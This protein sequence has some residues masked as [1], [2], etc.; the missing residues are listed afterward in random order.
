MRKIRLFFCAA[1]AFLSFLQDA[2]AQ[3]PIITTAVNRTTSTAGGFLDDVIAAGPGRIDNPYMICVDGSDNLYIADYDNSRIRKVDAVTGIITT[4]AGSAATG[5]GGDG[6]PATLAQLGAPGGGSR[7]VVGVAVDAAGNIYIGDA[8]NNKIRFVNASTGIISTF[9]G[10]GT[11]GFSGDGGPA[12]AAQLNGPRGIAV[13]A[14]GNVYF[15]DGENQRIR[16][17]IAGV[18]TIITIA[19]NGMAGPGT[20]GVVATTQRINNVRGLTVDASGNVYIADQGNNR[21]RRIA[22]FTNIITTVAG[23]GTAGNGGMGGPATAGQL[24]GPLDVEFDALGNMYIA[25][26]GVNRVKRVNTSG[27]IS[28][29]A[30]G[31][32]MGG[33]G[34]DGGPATASTA[35]LNTPASIAILSNPNYFYISDRSN[36]KIRLV[37][38]NSLPFFTRGTR[39]DTFVCQNS[40]LNNIAPLFPVMDSDWA[41]YANLVWSV[42]VPALHGTATAT[43]SDS[44]NGT[45]ITPASV[46]YTPTLGYSGLDTFTVQITDGANTATTQVIVTVNPLPV[47]PPIGGP[48]EVCVGG[49]V[50]ETNSTGGGLWEASNS[51]VTIGSSTGIVT[52]VSVGFVTISY[53]VTNSC[54]FTRVV[55]IMTINTVPATPPAI[56]GPSIVCAGSGIILTNG[57]SG[58]VWT[59]SN[60][61]VATVGSAS[62]SVTGVAAG[63]VNITYTVTNSCGSAFVFAP[64]TVNPAPTPIAGSATSCVGASNTLTSSPAGIW[65][66]SNTAAATIG[67][68]SGVV[69]GVAPGTTTISYT[70]SNGCFAT[71][72][73]TVNNPP[74]PNTGTP[75]VCVGSTTTLS[76]ALPGGTWTSSSGIA[77]VGSSTGIVFGMTDGIPNITYTLGGCISVTTITINLVPFPINPPG[78][79]TMC[80]GGSAVLTSTPGAGTWSTVAGTG[81]VSLV[82]AGSSVTVTGATAGTA[83][84]SYTNSFGCARTK[85]VTVNITP[86]AISPTSASICVGNTV[87]L[88]NSVGGGTWTSGSANATV[89]SATGVVTG[90]T[91]GTANITYTIGSCSVSV[92]VTVNNGP[93]PIT[94]AG[95]VSVCV[96]ATA[97]LAD[98]TS[99]GTWS[100]VAGTGSV[101]LVAAGTSVTVTGVSAGTATISYTTGTGCAATKVI[102]VDN[103][104]AAISPSSAQVCTGS[105]VT[106][107]NS[108]SGGTWSSSATGVATVDPGG[109]VTGVAFGTATISYAIGTCVATAPVTVNLSPSAGTIV[110]SA[111]AC[112][113]LT[114]TLTNATSGGVWSSSNAAVATVGSTG[115]VTGVTVGPVIISYTVVNGCG[116]ATATHAMTVSAGASAGTITGVGML[117]AGTFTT[118]TSTVPG[119]TWSATNTR[120]TI[121]STGVLTGITPGIDT[122]LYSV[123]N[124]CGTAVSSHI[125][126]IGA[127]LTAGTISGP[128]SVCQGASITLTST[129]TGGA[130]TSSGP[131]ATVSGGVVTG[132]SGGMVTISYTVTSFC[133]TATATY[134]VLAIA[135]PDAGTVTGPI[136]LCAGMTAPYTTAGTGGT[137]SVTNATATITSGGVLTALSMGI[138]T[139]EYTVTN[140]CGTDVSSIAVTIGPA[141]TVSSNSGPAS[142]CEASSITLT[143][144][145]PGGVWSASNTNATVSGGVVTGVTAGSV[146]I[147]YTVTS[148]CGSVSAV[149]TIM[150]NPLPNAGTIVGPTIACVAASITLTDAAPGGTWNAS[151]SNATVSGGVVTGV[152]VGLVDISYTVTNSCGTA[153]AVSTITVDAAPTVAAISGPSNVCV[154]ATITLTD[155]TP[156]GTWSSS[157]TDATVSGG[158]VTGVTAG[159]TII[160]Y[161]VT[162]ACGSADATAA[163]TIDPLPDAGTIVGPSN[164]CVA[165]TITLT[166]AAPGGTWSSSS[167]D[168]TVVGGV[169]TGVTAG[170]VN[171]SYSV[172]NVCGT[173][174]AV[175]P[176]TVDPLPDAGVISGPSDVCVGGAITLTGSVSGGTWSASSADA[177]VAGGVVTG[178]SAGVVDISYSVTNVC[179]TAVASVPVNVVTTP[180]VA[181]ITGPATVCRGGSMTLANATAGGTW[182]ASNTNATVSSGGVVTGTTTGTVTIS[183]TVTN[184]CGTVT[185]T[186]LINITT[187][188]SAGSI[189]GPASVCVGQ[190][191]TLTNGVMGGTWSS[192]NTAV[193]TVAGG[194]VSGVTV[195]SAIISYT[196]SNSCGSRSVTRAVSVLPATDCSGVGVKGITAVQDEIKLYPNP[197]H[198]AFTMNL[199]TENDEQ[200]MVVVTNI[201]GKKVKEFTTTTNKATDVQ[202]NTAPGIYLLTATTTNGRY[203]VK[204]TVE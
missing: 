33:Y 113:G 163:I 183:Y 176:I 148:S 72:A 63:T 103:T 31:N 7:G 151:N 38:P 9:A 149:S 140:A 193:A 177:T 81:S 41:S 83:T 28:I 144:A 66:S 13:D 68:S 142:V 55:R 99:G 80:V 200:V 76:N 136:I 198:G 196:M 44:S 36:S 84:V 59:S 181:T 17:V 147:S 191:I 14:L 204:I 159:S 112:T 97:V 186:K 6:V 82:A 166:D 57:T 79:V 141:L 132:V 65:V 24:S 131:A 53:T 50:T 98:A 194:L 48:G 51:N 60:L 87:A 4:V 34:G 133:G 100:T 102:T 180:T 21:V 156:G 47:V 134:P 30:G 167:A 46:L 165:A 168:A 145:T 2:N 67:S 52:G 143:N 171:I 160:S 201:I 71:R 89:G 56:G 96:G 108:V 12:T 158:V 164:V 122:I 172:T 26:F 178:V 109:V 74:G 190:N 18:G 93:A 54:G 1:L 40:G 106:L 150:V 27:I 95:A 154:A 187:A 116:T 8:S 3:N 94:P 45:I 39:V 15:S 115:I 202:L 75:T 77:V 173:A 127:F 10:T 105:T 78:A 126:T 152:S 121:T 91:A 130:W 138:D 22:P 111:S 135:T 11:A 124:A 25:D 62:G 73:V 170:T 20:D 125:V 43:F 58:G 35:R 86:A 37:K 92:P 192:N 110:G 146:D 161:T 185:A 184:A 129:A 85:E 19:G 203:V 162:N 70:L 101:S 117:C 169:V 195:G 49:S 32:S 29:V 182:S 104:P 16:M 188:P 5:S 69:M 42:S 64:V 88:T 157:T 90:V 137:W 107:S 118:L 179:G 175:V 128:T 61:S 114:T 123:T 155:A 197:N 120:A 189:S 139:V 119:G 174:D 199:L 153:S 23:T